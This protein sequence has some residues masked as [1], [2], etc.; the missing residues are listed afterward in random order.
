MIG[1]AMRVLFAASPWR[2]SYYSMVPLGWAL[3]AAGHEVQVVCPPGFAD[4][5]TAAGL[6][7]APVAADLDLLRFARFGA[8]AGYGHPEGG[9]GIPLLHPV[10]GEELPPGTE[11]D[12]AGLMRES[13]IPLMDGLMKSIG[14]VAD[15]AVG[16][17]PDLVVTELMCPDGVV[18]ARAAGVPSILQLWGPVGPEESEPG[19]AFFRDMYPKMFARH[20]LPADAPA[21]DAAIDICPPAIGPGLTRTPRLPMRYVPHNGPTVTPSWVLEPPARRRVGVVWGTSLTQIF[22][23]AAFLPPLLLEALAEED[24]E[25]VLALGEADRARLGPLPANVRAIGHVPLHLL[26]PTCSVMIHHGGAGSTMT[27]VDA[28]VPHLTITFAPE[29]DA[30]GRRVAAAGAGLHLPGRGV[31]AGAIRDAV[32]RL[33][34]EPAFG[35]VAG[36]LRAVNREL[37][38]PAAVVERLSALA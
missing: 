11:I 24:V 17:R 27:A 18:A 13:L 5:V 19:L 7:A 35:E 16:W 25:V 14:E 26:A 2:A 34:R 38:T 36:R 21:F 20:G 37:P 32:R 15:F 23:A 12:L 31:T 22:G 30:V 28:G 4:V 29:Q 8:M 9:G 1:E 3:L 10:T 33:L 6:S